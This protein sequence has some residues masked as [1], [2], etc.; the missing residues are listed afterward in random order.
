LWIGF[1]RHALL[2][3]DRTQ[4]LKGGYIASIGIH[5][6]HGQVFFFGLVVFAGV[7]I[8]IRP[9]ENAYFFRSTASGKEQ[10]T[11]QKPE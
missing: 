2:K 4:S 6:L 10:T 7:E 1:Q 5:S 11:E 3:P 8:A 9:F